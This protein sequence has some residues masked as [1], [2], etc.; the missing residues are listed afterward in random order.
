MSPLESTDFKSYYSQVQKRQKKRHFIF[1]CYLFPFH[2][3]CLSL[4]LS[5]S[6]P[7]TKDNVSPTKHSASIGR[8]GFFGLIR[9]LDSYCL[10][11]RQTTTI[12]YWWCY[13]TE[14]PLNTYLFKVSE[15]YFYFL[16]NRLYFITFQRNF[17]LIEGKRRRRSLSS[18]SKQLLLTCS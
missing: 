8:V 16:K 2:S 18:I 9:F 4:S 12:V 5:L 3:V 6:L 13:H 14:T 11:F 1:C 15:D 7:P 17:S 10:F